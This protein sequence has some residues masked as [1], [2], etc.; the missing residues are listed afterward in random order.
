M[1][2]KLDRMLNEVKLK[3]AKEQEGSNLSGFE[4]DETC[5]EDEHESTLLSMAKQSALQPAKLTKKQ[6]KAMESNRLT[7]IEASCGVEGLCTK[8]TDVQAFRTPPTTSTSSSSEKSKTVSPPEPTKAYEN[9]RQPAVMDDVQF[10]SII[11]NNV[12]NSKKSEIEEKKLQLE[13]KKHRAEKKKM[14]IMEM[15]QQ[16]RIAEQRQRAEEVKKQ[17]EFNNNLLMTLT[18]FITT[19]S[20]SYSSQ[21]RNANT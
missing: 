12:N 16:A 14:K 2:Q 8:P 3:Y 19:F 5:L 17:Q 6:E 20:Q 11:S 13:K 7:S 18:N 15:E 1:R 10:M 21:F 4:G 9:R